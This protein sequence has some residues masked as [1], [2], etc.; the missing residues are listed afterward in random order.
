MSLPARLRSNPDRVVGVAA[1]FDPTSPRAMLTVCL[2][3][4]EP[5][6]TKRLAAADVGVGNR[7][8]SDKD[9]GSPP[10]PIR[11]EP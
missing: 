10:G 7:E 2:G 4:S 1:D 8:A 11:G 3:E 5:S 9:A 6:G